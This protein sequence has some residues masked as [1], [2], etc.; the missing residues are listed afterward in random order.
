MIVYCIIRDAIVVVYS[1]AIRRGP[2]RIENT[3]HLHFPT[4][5]HLQLLVYM[6]FVVYN[7][8]HCTDNAANFYVTNCCDVQTESHKLS[9]TVHTHLL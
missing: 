1:A 3:P 8:V 6:H 2:K 9:S 4:A 5:M 7:V